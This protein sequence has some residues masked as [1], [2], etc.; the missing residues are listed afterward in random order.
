[1]CGGRK[2]DVNIAINKLVVFKREGKSACNVKIDEKILE[3]AS[4]FV[5]LSVVTNKNDECGKEVKFK[6]SCGAR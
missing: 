4:K 3:I 6:A 5:Y 1:M 2:L